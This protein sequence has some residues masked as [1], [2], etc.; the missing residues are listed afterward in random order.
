MIKLFLEVYEQIDSG[1]FDR[2]EV[3]GYE[4]Q[5]IKRKR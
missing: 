5:V 1:G 4:R 2:V 3:L